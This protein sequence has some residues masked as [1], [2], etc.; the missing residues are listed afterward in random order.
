MNRYQDKKV[1]VLGMAKSGVA[2]AKLLH[3][4]GAHVVA[5]DQKPREEAAGAEELEALGIRVICGGHPDDLIHPGISLVVKNP[6]I[7][8]EAAPVA[9]AL[10]LGIPVVTEVELA[11]QVSRAPMIGIT[12][13]NGKTTTTT[14]IGL[15]LREAGIDALTGGNIG[16]VLCGLAEE[17][18]PDQWLVAELS[19]FQL[20]GTAAFRPKIGVLLNVYP[21]HLDY[22]HTMDEYRAA[23]WKLFANQTADD[24]AIL[25]YDQADACPDLQS[26]AAQVYFFSKHRPVPRGTYVENGSILFVGAAGEREEILPVEK[27]SVAHLDNALAAALACKLAGADNG[28]IARVLESFAGVEHRMEYVATIAGVKYYNDS[29]ATN[30]EA[31]SRALQALKEPVVWICGGL[32]RGVTFHDL[33]PVIQPRVKAVVAFGETAPILLARAKEAGI[34]TLIHVDTVEKAVIAASEAASPGDAVLLSPAC[35]SWDMFPSFEVRGS[36]FKDVVHRLKTS[37]A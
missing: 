1:V 16:T 2:V 17:A 32:D 27:L 6:G 34:N 28:S 30:A 31:A 14:L 15:I 19:S 20:M 33:I 29:K 4:F 12:G 26:L 37:L 22:H 8:Y 23:K 21:A 18:R 36:M 24:I 35:A 10:E 25:P 7:P 5:N 3:R 9:R 13:S 11:Y